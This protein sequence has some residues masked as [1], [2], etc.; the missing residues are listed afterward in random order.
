MTVEGLQI[1]L[2]VIFGVAT[3]LVFYEWRQRVAW[4]H[5]LDYSPVTDY[6]FINGWGATVLLGS[7]IIF[8]VLG[9]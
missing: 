8:L 6:A 1:I 3:A 7:W 2:T 9:G 5:G 4:K